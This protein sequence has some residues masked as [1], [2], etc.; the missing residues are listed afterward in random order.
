MLKFGIPYQLN[1]L[2]AM[3][4]DDGM[5]LFLGSILGPTGVGLLGW[6]QKW[7]FAPLRFFM[8]Q[9]IKVTFP[10]FS[11]MQDNKKELSNAL[12]KSIFYIC[13]LVFPSLTFLIIVAPSLVE[14]IPKYNKWSPALLALMLLSANAAIAAVTTPITNA[15]NAIGKISLTFK[16]MI[17]W[18]TLTWLFVPALAISYGV[19]G[20]AL[21]FVLVG[22]SSVVAL[23]LAK[24]YVEINYLEILLKPI[25]ISGVVLGVVFAVKSLIS[26]SVLQISLMSLFGFIVYI[27]ATLILE[28][29]ILNYLKRK[30]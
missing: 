24:K 19:S 28:P 1:T 10:A 22:L 9:V 13:L 25:L 4:K 20:A 8:D 11:R 21:G 16:L 5:T 6:A 27:I 29:N 17:M 30:K 2:L 15:F 7:A 23:Y 26:V 12:S 18:T 14:V 3:V